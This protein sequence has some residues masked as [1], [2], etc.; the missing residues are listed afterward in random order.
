MKKLLILLSFLL[1]GGFAFAQ[2]G[3]VKFQETTMSSL[4]SQATKANKP[5]FVD[6]YATWCGPCKYMASKVFTQ[7]K[8]GAYFNANF[9]NAKFDAEKGEGIEVAKKYNVTAYPTFLILDAKGNETARIVG[10]ADV[11]DFI[12]IVKEKVK[13]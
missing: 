11:D 1:V 7:D 5:I 4:M 12:N 8:A 9:I 6:V 2:S 3:G 13:K 10:G